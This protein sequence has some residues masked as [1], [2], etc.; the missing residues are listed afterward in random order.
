M[1]TLFMT[2][3]AAACLFANDLQAQS[4]VTFTPEKPMPG[5]KISFTYDPA[6]TSAVSTNDAKAYAYLLEG[7][8]PV[9]QEIKLTKNGTAYK[10][11]IT[12]NDT[13]LAFF[14]TF[15]KDNAMD[16]GKGLG[17]HSY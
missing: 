3:L 6:A 9:V 12:T 15:S 5:Q 11:E 7:I 17:Y 10:G 13:T 14:L 2:L 4:T 8:A 1:R 16:N